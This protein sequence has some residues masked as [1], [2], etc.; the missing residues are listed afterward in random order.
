MFFDSLTFLVFFAV[1]F[2]AFWILFSRT[3]MAR[4]GFLLLTSYVFYG[5]WDWRFLSLILISSIVDFLLG[6]SMEKAKNQRARKRLLVLSLVVNLGL[7]GVFKYFNFFIDSLDVLLEVVGT[8][9]AGAHL[10]VVLP[11][12]ISFY[13][14]Q[15]LSYT[16]DIYR[17]RMKAVNDPI[18]F[19]TFVAFFP[20]LVAGPIERARD[21][22]PQ[23]GNE[24]PG[25]D[26]SAA[27]SGLLLAMWG[28]FKKVVIADRLGT[29]VDATFGASV[30]LDANYAALGLI[31]FAGQLYLDFSAYSDIARGISRML[32]YRLSENFRRP[33]FAA[34]FSDFWKRWHITLSSWFRDYVYIPLGGNRGTRARVAFNAL[35]VF[36]VSGLWHGAS[37]NFVIWGGLN[38]LFLVLIDPLLERS[39]R[40]LGTLG[41]M[42]T[43]VVVT[44]CWTL[45]LSFFRG[46]TF[47]QAGHML[48]AL[49][50]NGS[51][52]PDEL[53]HF[54]W[55]LLAGSVVF[56]L[57][58]EAVQERW[59][60]S[61]EFVLNRPR[62]VRWSVY[63]TLC[64]AIVFL[65]AY[66]VDVT[67][68]Q[69]IYFQF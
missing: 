35:V 20:Q 64:M 47:E 9:V 31:C 51:L 67:D 46:Q 3:K 41:R 52:V 6:M 58:V 39:L 1:A 26:V 4:N 66:G 37:W 43:A 53:A 21:L 24:H 34:S 8:S 38:G 59:A 63:F 15:T 61:P 19:F 65:G 7:L 14:F 17:G 12:G 30:G 42:L 28:L 29:V 48:R 11:V 18:Q 16:L 27:R 36:L 13:T 68:Q 62:A 49:M 54:P 2:S 22:L 10:E 23:F 57:A 32:G 25:F 33:Y 44:A 5:W 40:G 60:Q 56:L 69:F 55:K 50:T 45:S